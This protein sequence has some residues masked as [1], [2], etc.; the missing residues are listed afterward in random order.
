MSFVPKLVVA[1]FNRDK[2]REL[3]ALLNLSGVELVSL[4]DIPGAVSPEENG[5]TLEANALLKAR[6]AHA[7]TRLGAIGDDT[8]LE[9][10]ALDG[11]PGVMS[12]RYS[13]EGATYASNV[14]L[15]LENLR[16]IVQEKRT[17]RFRTVCAAVLDDGSEIVA[18]GTIE[19]C[20]TEVARGNQGFGYDPVFEVAGTGRTLAELSAQEKNR[21]SHRSR[22]IL[23][24]RKPLEDRLRR[25][26]WGG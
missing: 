23:A 15:L 25:Q 14:K 5:D 21:V 7:F 12:A 8:G 2:L 9:V 17:A 19:G 6:A 20:I 4:A 24:L 10:D 18:E 16:G 1:T 3:V 13:G 22:A 26:G 11:A